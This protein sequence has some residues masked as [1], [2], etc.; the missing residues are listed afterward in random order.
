MASRT[1]S[2]TPGTAECFS[3]TLV[4]F[5]RRW[6]CRGGDGGDGGLGSASPLDESPGVPGDPGVRQQHLQARQVLQEGL[7]ALWH[8]LWLQAFDALSIKF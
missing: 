6:S 3:L 5:F 1:G 8:N 4:V 2:T 7:N